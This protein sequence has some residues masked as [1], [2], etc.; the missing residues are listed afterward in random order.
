MENTP[1]NKKK[2]PTF[3]AAWKKKEGNAP[4]S[5]PTSKSDVV[6]YERLRQARW[7]HELEKLIEYFHLPRNATDTEIEVAQRQDYE[8]D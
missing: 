3:L 7:K 6:P 2:E 8:F 5:S 1:E 4:L